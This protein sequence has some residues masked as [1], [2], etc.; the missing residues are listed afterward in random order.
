ML[1]NVLAVITAFITIILLLSIVVTGLAQATQAALRLRGRN[2]LTGVTRVLEATQRVTNAS[3][4]E[5]R[6]TAARVLNSTNLAAV[7]HVSKPDGILR[8]VVLGPRTTWV[9]ARELAAAIENE[10][11]QRTTVADQPPA[12]IVD[13]ADIDSRDPLFKAIK[14]AEPSWCKRFQYFMRLI[15][16]AWSLIIAF[17]FQVS[18][19]LLFSS[20][21]QDPSLTS[22]I[23]EDQPAVTRIAEQALAEDEYDLTSDQALDE[24]AKLYPQFAD[25]IAQ[26][27]NAAP[28]KAELV[29]QLVDVLPDVAERPAVVATYSNLIDGLVKRVDTTPGDASTAAADKLSAF[30]I[31]WWHGGAGFYTDKAS[32]GLDFSIIIGV[33]FT[34]ILLT[35]GAPFWFEQ[36]RTLAAL[37]DPRAVAAELKRTREDA[38]VDVEVA[39]SVKSKRKRQSEP[40]PED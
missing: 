39:A 37:R 33:L 20:L 38:E 13:A 32:G 4:R 27:G 40:D 2:L 15:T 14:R 5:K 10:H 26:A 16:I 17:G 31:T 24:L 6:E 11:A 30:G 1:T 9:E 12:P 21:S 25:D 3:R 8:R 7:D 23:L 19:P 36:L 22:K 35:F 18:A 34:A 28:T 29:Q